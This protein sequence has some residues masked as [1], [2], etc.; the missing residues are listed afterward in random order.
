MIDPR[1]VTL[2]NI[3][4]LKV[5]HVYLTYVDRP[6]Y[7]R[8]VSHTNPVHRPNFMHTYPLQPK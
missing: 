2:T 4:V 8:T 5:F 6:A 3:I 7:G 1:F